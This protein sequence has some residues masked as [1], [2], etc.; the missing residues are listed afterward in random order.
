ME[1]TNASKAI[2]AIKKKNEKAVRVLKEALKEE[3]GITLHLLPDIYP[4]GEER[5]V[6][7]ECLGVELGVDQ[8]PTAADA[9]VIN[10]ETVS[11]VAEAID[12]RKPCFSKNVTVVGKLNGGE[13]PHVFLDVPI[14]TSIGELIERAGGINGIY[15]E[16]IVGGPFTG[17]AAQEDTPVSYTHLTLPTKL[18][19]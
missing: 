14:G 15:G 13:E 17:H 4:M 2:F 8:L 16:I 5:A 7:R 9:V 12:E 11:R 1:L 19:V 18:E 10:V 3:E 6:V